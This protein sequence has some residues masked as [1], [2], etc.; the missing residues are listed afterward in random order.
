[1]VTALV[2]VNPLP[3]IVMVVPAAPE[4]G[5]KD[6]ISKSMAKFTEELTVPPGVVTAI[7]PVTAPA[8]TMAVICVSLLTVKVVAATPPKATAVD[9]VKCVPVMVTLVP[10]VPEVGVKELIVGDGVVL[11]VELS[12]LQLTKAARLNMRTRPKATARI[13]EQ[14]VRVSRGILPP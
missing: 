14:V 11:V 6:V 13:K 9:P 5:V 8:G 2:S 1:M 4:L 3:L 7:F 10:T 12:P